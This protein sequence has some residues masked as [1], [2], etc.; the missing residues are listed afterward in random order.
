MTTAVRMRPFIH[1]V[2]RERSMATNFRWV[3]T[4]DTDE[5]R[6]VQF[7]VAGDDLP[8]LF[9][10][11]PDDLR[12]CTCSASRRGKIHL[13][14]TDAQAGKDI[15]RARCTRSGPRWRWGPSGC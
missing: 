9:G 15:F 4:I 1:A 10:V 11:I 8:G 6:Y 13:F 12:H 14:G 2:K 7:F 3:T 5:R